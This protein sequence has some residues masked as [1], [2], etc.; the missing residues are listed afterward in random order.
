MGKLVVTS[1]ITL[2]NVVEEPHKWSGEFQSEDTGVLNDAVL[3][4]ADILLLGRTTYE[5]FA[6]AWPTRSGDPFSDKFNSMPKY[7]VS[8]TLEKAEWNNSTIIDSDWVERVRA[9]KQDRTCSSGAARRSCR[10]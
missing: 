4:E 7:V 5:G 10:A 6:A 8:T 3:R 2:D 9:A 1:F